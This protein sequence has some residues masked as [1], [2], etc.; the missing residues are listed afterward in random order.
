MPVA[1]PLACLGLVG[2]DGKYRGGGEA[3]RRGGLLE[4]E[5]TGMTSRLSLNTGQAE[6]RAAQERRSERCEHRRR[7]AQEGRARRPLRSPAPPGDVYSSPRARR[8]AR[9]HQCAART[10]ETE[11]LLMGSVCAR[12]A[13]TRCTAGGVG[14]GPFCLEEA[15]LF[16]VWILFSVCFQCVTPTPTR[17]VCT[18]VRDG[19]SCAGGRLLPWLRLSSAV[20]HQAHGPP[21]RTR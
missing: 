8:S 4:R 17:C 20:G 13:R 12:V 21:P 3:T 9:L 6:G 15:V 11:L 16:S 2:P 18:A 5:A 10:F 1:Q 19:I 7:Q 14:F